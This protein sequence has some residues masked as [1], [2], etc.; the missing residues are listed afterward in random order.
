MVN[1]TT[2]SVFYSGL[3]RAL[4]SGIQFTITI[5]I[6]RI[7]SPADY[8]LI[9]ML[10]IFYA[11]SQAFVDSGLSAALVQ[12][13]DCTEIDYN[14]V[15]WFNIFISIVLYIVLYFS[16]PI[17]ANLFENKL[18]ILLVRIYS[19]NLVISSLTMVHR[20]IMMKRLMFKELS[21]VGFLSS[22]ISGLLAILLVYKGYSYWALVFQLLSSSVILGILVVFLCKW[23]PLFKFSIKSFKTLFI[24]GMPILVTAII[25]SI[26]NNIYS[27]IIGSKYN[28]NDLGIYNRAYS[29]S[30]F[31][32]INV[33]DATAR[34]LF[35]VYSIIQDNKEKL[36]KEKL[37]A[38]H[39]LMFVV[40]PINIFILFNAKDLITLLL[41][42][43]W[44]EMTPIL[45]ILCF[46]NIW[47]PMVNLNLNTIKVLGKTNILLRMEFVKKSIGLTVLYITY[48][49][50][51]IIMVWGQL[52]YSFV[53][54]LISLI[55]IQKISIISIKDQIKQ[56][57]LLII[58]SFLSVS[59]A[60][61]ITK[62]INGLL[63]K[64]VVSGTIVTILY[65]AMEILT[66]KDIK[67]LLYK[68]L[69]KT[70]L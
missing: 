68:T 39:L 32:P 35:P 63:L 31:V 37:K 6:A 65:S 45:Q 59:V 8:G 15:Y 23:K 4:V 44:I 61:L 50:G 20:T 18:L 2:K 60:F 27:L 25:N 69:K 19:L 57:Y 14:S 30:A 55:Y 3:E 33:G 51:L 58:F 17:I 13:K 34:A 62:S 43:K 47:Y 26:Y 48:N 10:S 54:L 12:K 46:S 22:L 24:F 28:A 52:L 67:L 1:T 38:L 49:Y 56:V 66:R 11:F 9:A 53:D 7:L 40:V 64:L 16:A 42:E 29:L 5:V 70:I 41:T 36:K 21:I